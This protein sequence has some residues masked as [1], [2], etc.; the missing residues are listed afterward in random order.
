MFDDTPS[1]E[2]KRDDKRKTRKGIN[3]FIFCV[4]RAFVLSRQLS[5][6]GNSAASRRAKLVKPGSMHYSVPKPTLN[7]TPQHISGRNSSQHWTMSKAL[8][9]LFTNLL[10]QAR[11]SAKEEI[12]FN[13][14]PVEHHVTRKKNRTTVT[15]AAG[16]VK[17]AEMTYRKK[18]A[19]WIRSFERSSTKYE[20][21]Q[22]FGPWSTWELTLKNFSA[23]IKPESFLRGVSGAEKHGNPDV[24]GK[25]GDGLKSAIDYLVRHGVNVL[26]VTAGFTTR[27]ILGM[28]GHSYVQQD[29]NKQTERNVVIKLTFMPDVPQLLELRRSY[30]TENE[31]ESFCPDTF[32]PMSICLPIGA[33]SVYVHMDGLES[34]PSAILL[35]EE[36]RGKYY[37]RGMPVCGTDDNF[38]FGYN[39]ADPKS[40]LIDGRDRSAMNPK[41]T[42]KEVDDLLCGGIEISPR[43]RRKLVVE[44]TRGKEWTRHGDIRPGKWGE[45]T[46]KLIQ[47]ESRIMFGNTILVNTPTGLCTMVAAF[48]NLKPEPCHRALDEGTTL[49]KSF[50]EDLRSLPREEI[51]DENGAASGWAST[52]KGKLLRLTGATS[53]ASVEFP[54]TLGE[55]HVVWVEKDVVLVSRRSLKVDLKQE[56]VETAKFL[57]DVIPSSMYRELSFQPSSDPAFEVYHL[58]MTAEHRPDKSSSAVVNGALNA[59]NGLL[60]GD[61]GAH[62]LPAGDG[63]NAGAEV[64]PSRALPAPAPVAAVADEEANPQATAE[65]GGDESDGEGMDEGEQGREESESRDPEVR[66]LCGGKRVRDAVEGEATTKRNKQE[67][68]ES[69]EGGG[70][71]VTSPAL[72]QNTPVAEKGAGM[73]AVS[74][75][76][77]E[78]RTSEGERAFASV[79]TE[80]PR[81][82]EGEA[83][84]VVA[85]IQP[86]LPDQAVSE[87]PGIIPEA[88][89]EGV[90]PSPAHDMAEAAPI[91]APERN[92]EELGAFLSGGDL[93][94]ALV[95]VE[96]H[97]MGGE[98]GSVD[99]YRIAGRKDNEGE[100]SARFSAV[101]ASER[102]RRVLESAVKKPGVDISLFSWD[103]PDALAAFV[104]Q[105]AGRIFVNLHHGSKPVGEWG[106]DD[107]PTQIA[108]AMAHVRSATPVDVHSHAWSVEFRKWVKSEDL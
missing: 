64:S 96:R 53:F 78:S 31:R 85:P 86:D 63:E 103:E 90:E 2:P 41:L 75:K 92:G 40:T 38:L 14:P 27:G 71:G 46:L 20:A 69:E 70:S 43:L 30:Y 89:V 101:V 21:S 51:D 19:K 8:L 55:K 15:F 39:L 29:Y 52:V 93:A 105:D 11:I 32:D 42:R 95:H 59:P 66:P 1:P 100:L 26:V 60:P 84:A 50:V 37:N 65:E 76:V 72:A 49:V 12:P 10:D 82:A 80:E 54:G 23:Y 22:V 33:D 48:R 102:A 3:S 88:E 62:V 73:P 81:S 87:S 13:T 18:E 16:D 107:L 83:A 98:G 17:V 25:Y 58:I 9:E 79:K 91:S 67:A 35:G 99:L 36:F 74:V 24:I 61:G 104:G 56:G 108:S 47:Q 57:H 97:A 7:K 94:P 106:A 34:P 28:N 77:E 44:L 6:K 4:P 68:S 45:R 5:Q